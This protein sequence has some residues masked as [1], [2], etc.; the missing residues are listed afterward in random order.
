MKLLRTCNH[1]GV[2]LG[3]FFA[4]ILLDTPHPFRFFERAAWKA[5]EGVGLAFLEIPPLS[6]WF[7]RRYFR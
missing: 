2:W 3:H 7:L 5:F 1:G 6:A 4:A